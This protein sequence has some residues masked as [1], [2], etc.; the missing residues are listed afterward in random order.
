MFFQKWKH[1]HNKKSIPVFDGMMRKNINLR[2][3]FNQH[4]KTD[5]PMVYNSGPFLK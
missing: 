1:K 5:V 4:P 3:I 2:H